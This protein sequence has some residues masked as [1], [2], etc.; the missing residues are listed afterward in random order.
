[1]LIGGSGYTLLP[2][3]L[4]D[5]QIARLKTVIPTDLYENTFS[6]E[7]YNQGLD[8]L[9]SYEERVI[10]T[11]PEEI[12]AGLVFS[13]S[14][15]T[16]RTGKNV[17]RLIYTPAGV[18]PAKQLHYDF[19]NFTAVTVIEGRGTIVDL[20]PLE[21]PGVTT[22]RLFPTDSA[23][24]TPKGKSL[25]LTGTNNIEQLK[26]KATAHGLNKASDD[27]PR[28]VLQTT[29]NLER[30][31]LEWMLDNPRSKQRQRPRKHGRR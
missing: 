5:S 2:S 17:H 4:D 15:S 21:K 28:R 3:L 13:R 1:M 16:Q 6:S 31:A 30:R 29:I 27:G 8:W 19:S 23:F 24:A 10:A 11:F 25:L 18:T 12:R 22:P 14:T 9:K 20:D 7:L 26:G